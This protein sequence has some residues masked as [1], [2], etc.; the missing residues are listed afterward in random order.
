MHLRALFFLLLF[1]CVSSAKL[2]AQ[3]LDGR[4]LVHTTLL[5]DTTEVQPGKSFRLGVLFELAEGWH[6]YW[7]NPGDAGLKTDLVWEAPEGFS[8]GEMGWPVPQRVVEPGDL[9]VYAYKGTVLFF[10]DVLPPQ[11]IQGSEVTFRVNANWLVC[12]A[13]CIPG[14]G[15]MELTLPVGDGA[16]PNNTEIF[17]SAAASLPKPGA[18]PLGIQWERQGAGWTVK[19][20][21]IPEGITSVDFFPYEDSP[22]GAGH[23]TA[24][25]P[26]GGEA[27]LKVPASAEVRGLLV[28]KGPGG[29]A[30]TVESPA[31]PPDAAV[32]VGEDPASGVDSSQP[33]ARIIDPG[34]TL[35]TALF[36]GFLGGLILNLMPCVLP[37]ISLKIFGFLR[38]AGE[39]RARI[40]AH[41]LAFCG[42]V[43]LW[44]LG[45]ALVIVLL[46]SGG[47]Q[48]TWAFQFQN[49][50]FMLFISAVVF[51]FAL[52]LFGVF[53][54]VLPGGANSKIAEAGE[55]DGLGG[56][57]F[58][59]IFATLLATPCTAPF[60]GSSL[61]FAFSQPAPVIFGMFASVAFGMSLPYLLLSAQP[62]WVRYLPRPG[63]WMERL[64]QFM[65]FPLLATLIW[66]L[67][68]IGGQ[69]GVSGIVWTTALLLCLGFA[70]WLYGVYF[71]Q[72]AGARSRRT[73]GVAAI[74]VVVLGG[75]YFGALFATSS[76]PSAVSENKG[77]EGIAWVPFSRSALDSEL[78]AGRSV[79]LDFTADWCLTC[80]FN[81]RTAIN[82]P[83][84]RE[85][86][87]EHGVIPMKAD[88]TNSNPE[89]TEMLRSFGRVGV[90]FYV[91]YPR[92]AKAA[93][94]VLPELLTESLVLERIGAA[95]TQ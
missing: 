94:V 25:S 29:G 56:S 20:T 91:F 11:E 51:V 46:K 72:P 28:L 88:W 63:V 36:F 69:K 61:G 47:A 2:G 95:L 70:A 37:V 89:I 93:P 90:P 30:W 26:S 50:W 60:L 43:F 5:A 76:A 85:L 87:E 74:V 58:Q 38:Q 78:A 12:E 71:C 42:G 24:Q 45:L 92:G 14:E 19:L 53:E 54:I 83:A 81:E 82:T 15:S 41:G 23:A 84:V 27:T 32:P 59:G 48:V 6:I 3:V 13:I 79:F 34:M 9:Q 57:F 68:V 75:W 65:G 77:K 64:K 40:L 86:F 10:V 35:W 80:K 17:E 62:G 8:V 67:S 31:I 44:F 22:Q 1:F 7:R 33:I 4:V 52:N 16:R 66:L 18:P 73:A 55:K 39:S 49:P 21:A